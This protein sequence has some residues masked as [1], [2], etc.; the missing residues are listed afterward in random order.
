[1]SGR[2]SPIFARRP[3]AAPVRAI[4]IQSAAGRNIRSDV[5]VVAPSIAHDAVPLP[6][7]L[8]RRLKREERAPK[9]SQRIVMVASGSTPARPRGEDVAAPVVSAPSS[10]SVRARPAPEATL[11]DLEKS[12]AAKLTRT[13]D[14]RVATTIQKSL[15]VDAEYSQAITEHVYATLYDKMV[16]ER[17]RLG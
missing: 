6:G 13:I 4:P 8:A 7:L 5:V 2:V 3:V 14:K 16:L 17:E 11:A 15:S 10:R 9:Q 1:M 12:L